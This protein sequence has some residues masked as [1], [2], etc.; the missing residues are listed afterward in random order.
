PYPVY[1][2]RGEGSRVWCQDSREYLDF[3]NGFGAMVVGHGHPLIVEACRKAASRGTHFAVTTEIAVEY[4]EELCRRFNLE[5]IRFTNSGTEST[6]DAI[7][8]ARA[9]T[10]RDVVCKIEGSYHG[11]HDAVM[12]SVI[13]NAD[14]MGGRER[15]A[16]APVSKGLVKDASK[17][18]EVVP[19]NDAD[20]LEQVLNQR[21][22]EIACL[23]MEPAMMN[24]G[25]VVPQPGYLQRARELCTKQGV[26]FIFDEI[27]TGCT[28]AAGGAIERFGVQPDLVCLAK[29]IAGGL[30]AGAFGG[31]KD[32]MFLIER[33]VSQMGTYNG[34][35]L[36]A[37]TGLVT[38]RE[39]LTPQAYQHLARLGTR[40]A[41]GCR[42][43]IDRYGLPAHTIDL[44]AKGCVSYRPTPMKNYRDFLN[45]LP[46]L[47]GA[48]YPW[49]LNR[50][51][52]MTPG[53]EEQWTLSVQ[54]SDADIDQYIGVF[55]EFCRVLTA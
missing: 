8:V 51:I 3:H 23:I 45:T 2:E 35:P 13:P 54:H 44:G 52:F 19:F 36:V 10:G 48:S 53:D 17:Y 4:G 20:F 12:F 28:I 43:A 14:V 30:P 33:G 29:A 24:L 22:Q 11:H 41:T 5:A 7:R 26:I 39:I 18:I 40:L 42:K 1:L 34:N 47:F 32:L 55:T 16:K 25:I 31:R 50:G 38:L 9:A 6:M 27:K 49:L 46:E 21:G 15:P 37:H